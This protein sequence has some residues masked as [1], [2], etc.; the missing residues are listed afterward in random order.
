[1]ITST[2]R[3][4]RETSHVIILDDSPTDATRV[5]SALRVCFE[6]AGIAIKLETLTNPSS[7]P[8]ALATHPD[9]VICD[10]SLRGQD[11]IMGLELI[12]NIKTKHPH[13]AFA[14]M[15]SN[16]DQLAKLDQIENAPA[17]L[18]PKTLLLPKVDPKHAPHIIALVLQHTN[19][20]RSFE[21][22]MPTGVEAALKRTLNWQKFDG[23]TV[24]CLIRQ[25]FSTNIVP[26]NSSLAYRFSEN[27]AL[28]LPPV[29]MDGVDVTEFETGRSGSAV[30]RAVPK[31]RNE[32]YE[33]SVVLK[34]SPIDSWLSE[35]RNFAQYVKWTLPYSWRVDVLGVGRVAKL[36]VI[37]YSLA[38]AGSADAKPLAHFLKQGQPAPV[39]VFID[40]VFDESHKVWYRNTSEGKSDLRSDLTER[41]F[42]SGRSQNIALREAFDR[43]EATRTFAL[44]CRERGAKR[45]A[46]ERAFQPVLQNSWRP[47][48]TCI[49]HGDLHGGN[50][51]A[52]SDGNGMAFIDFQDTGDLHVFTDFVVFENAIRK[53]GSTGWFDGSAM[54]A[55]E[56]DG[57]L[58]A[59]SEQPLP[60]AEQLPLGYSLIDSVRARAFANFPGEQRIHYF[61]H[62]AMFAVLMLRGEISPDATERIAAFFIACA[63]VLP[64]RFPRGDL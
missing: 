22:S 57:I 45:L 19:Q 20:N 50:V 29:I 60:R 12:E 15:T 5:A 47:Y 23:Q 17:F 49:C 7:L 30:F 14:A 31:I 40:S 42:G 48:Q 44:W 64:G 43:I 41:Y 13:I 52:S 54:M 37:G 8:A 53:D 46:L 56:R 21:I 9:I 35:L 10:V 24:A 62:A 32:P 61:V 59:L 11:D 26:T 25:V 63:D 4:P 33:V 36:G 16:L 3:F 58:A 2:P 55:I 1:M 27:G 18:L 6:S 34:F 38:F 28:G 51:M 39:K